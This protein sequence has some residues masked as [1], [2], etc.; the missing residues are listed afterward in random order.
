[1][2]I[3]NLKESFIIAFSTYSRVPMPQVE[4]NEQNMKYAVCF[5]PLVGL[6]S[7][8]LSWLW[9]SASVFF[10][11]GTI[12]RT[13]VLVLIPILV[14]GGIHLDGLLDT[15][16]AVSS[17][18]SREERLE[19]M[20]DSRCGAFAVIWCAAYLVMAFGVLSEMTLDRMG[21]LALVYVMAR[22]MSGWALV[23]FDKAKKS[24][25]LRTFADAAAND[26]AARVMSVFTAACSVLIII[27]SPARGAVCV[28]A[29]FLCFFLYRRKSMELF[30]GI[31]GDLAGCFL[32]LAELFMALGLVCAR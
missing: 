16:D 17:Y 11:F 29:G 15:A 32:C 2:S 26:A 12:F 10:G 5:F 18:R 20:K 24:G 9:F 7:G 21:Q 4:W 19:I 28:L 30:G 8:I 31:T 3:R 22:A 1:M 23:R 25:L 6:L 27:L 14:T 13:S